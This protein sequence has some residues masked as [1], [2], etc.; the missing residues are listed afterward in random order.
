MLRSRAAKYQT[1]RRSGQLNAKRQ[2]QM[3]HAKIQY[4]I[5]KKHTRIFQ[6]YILHVKIQYRNAQKQTHTHTHM[7]FLALSYTLKYN[8][9]F[10]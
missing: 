9:K 7:Y 4:Q 10:Y 2:R 5:T 6:Y 8:T 1:L 3:L